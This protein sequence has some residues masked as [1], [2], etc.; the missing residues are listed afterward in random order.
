MS[1]TA[2][3]LAVLF[4]LAL[5]TTAEARGTGYTL[6]DYSGKQAFKAVRP[7]IVAPNQNVFVGVQ[8]GSADNQRM[9]VLKLDKRGRPVRKFGRS[10]LASA[11][12]GTGFL[13]DTGAMLIRPDGSIVVTGSVAAGKND[14][15]LGIVRFSAAGKTLHKTR[16]DLNDSDLSPNFVLQRADGGVVA[17]GSGHVNDGRAI[18]MHGCAIGLTASLE[19]ESSF[20][21][22]CRMPAGADNA[23]FVDAVLQADGSIVAGLDAQV[24]GRPAANPELDPPEPLRLGYGVTKLLPN[25][26][27]DTSF[28][29]REGSTL[30]PF[31][32]LEEADCAGQL[33]Y[34]SRIAPR[35][36]G[37]WVVAGMVDGCRV[38][39]MGYSADGKLDPSFGSG[40]VV[41]TD[42]D[43]V[44]EMEYVTGFIATSSGGFAAIAQRFGLE[45]C[46]PYVVRWKA[47][48]SLAGKTRLNMRKLVGSKG[49]FGGG[50]AERKGGGLLVTTE[51]TGRRDKLAVIALTRAGKLDKSFGVGDVMIRR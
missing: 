34:A 24:L 50:I 32:T 17:G 2:L 9:G 39:L 38:G 44:K 28:G 37:G 22:S 33:P 12:T 26:D 27:V 47:D 21:S 29:E 31:A 16:H 49:Y 23:S 25:G 51:V 10:G 46:D 4:T 14:G 5:T 3:F 7:L 36:G 19:R 20:N 8:V 48:G 40:G 15:D 11:V 30:T 42:V 1:R 13:E 43:P 45:G 41:K 35:R 6:L 18:K